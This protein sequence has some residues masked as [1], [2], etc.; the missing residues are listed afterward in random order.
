MSS[1]IFSRDPIEVPFVETANRS[2]NTAIPAPGT[3]DILEKLDSVESRA[4]HGQ[5]PMIWDSADNFNI[6][7]IAGNK[8]IDFTSAIFFSNVGHSNPRVKKAI[9]SMLDKPIMGCYA[10]GNEIRAK[11]LK[12][13][14]IFLIFI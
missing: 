10:Y 11:Y 1:H 7:D 2:I 14:M 12:K 5:I 4:M 13:L 9:Q 3:K 8:F 6:F